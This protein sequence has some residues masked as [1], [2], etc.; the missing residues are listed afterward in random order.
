MNKGLL[1]F[2]IAA[3]LLGC[4]P[5]D[6]LKDEAYSVGYN[7]I[8]NEKC[9]GIAQPIFIPKKYDDSTGSGEVLSYFEAGIIDAQGNSNLCK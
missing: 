6:E 3:M 5:S 9:N 2:S 4:G 7:S 1:I 8:W